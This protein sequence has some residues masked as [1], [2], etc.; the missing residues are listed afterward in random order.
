M[1]YKQLLREFSTIYTYK[2]WKKCYKL[3][4]KINICV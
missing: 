3:N 1:D 2:L 4:G